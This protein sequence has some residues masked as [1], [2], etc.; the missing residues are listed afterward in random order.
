MKRLAVTMLLSLAS[1][2]AHAQPTAPPPPAQPS[3]RPEPYSPST[4]RNLSIGGALVGVGLTALVMN[5]SERPP[6]AAAP[7]LALLPSVG[8]WYAHDWWSTG[9]AL[10]LGGVAMLYLS[11]L[12]EIQCH[13]DASCGDGD[14][15]LG[16]AIGAFALGTIVDIV[17]APGAARAA[18][19]E[20]GLSITPTLGAGRAGVALT[21]SF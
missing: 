7:V 1:S 5:S 18:N 4:A 2:V 15:E 12:A 9:L 10:R 19:R 13:D 16:L 17:T 8:H 20:R 14:G 3:S 21:G 11:V 6:Y